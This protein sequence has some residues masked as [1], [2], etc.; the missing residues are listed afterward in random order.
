MG[1]SMCFP[2]LF[3]EFEHCNL[4]KIPNPS[5]KALVTHYNRKVPNHE[6]ETIYLHN[7]VFAH[8]TVTN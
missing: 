5:L 6:N 4:S 8:G 1:H 2:E 7:N 3:T